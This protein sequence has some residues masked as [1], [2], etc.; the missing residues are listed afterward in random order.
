[1]SSFVFRFN[2]LLISLFNHNLFSQYTLS[3]IRVTACFTINILYSHICLNCRTFYLKIVINKIIFVRLSFPGNAYAKILDEVL[4][5]SVRIMFGDWPIYLVQDNSPIHKSQPVRQWLEDPILKCMFCFGLP[6]HLILT[7]LKMYGLYCK[8]VG[9]SQ[10][11]NSKSNW[12]TCT[13]GVEKSPKV[14]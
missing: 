10:W 9:A 7:L 5:P 12:R 4:L 6:D 8:R 11:T 1:M 2:W 13:F 14:P 3:K